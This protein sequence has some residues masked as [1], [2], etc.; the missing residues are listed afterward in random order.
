MKKLFATLALSLFAA[1][2]MAWEMGV[3]GGR[4]FSSPDRNYAGFTLGKSL[5][6][7]SVTAG[8]HR[9]V[10]GDNDQDRFSVTAGYDVAKVGP[11]TITPVVG[12]AYL[13]NQTSANGLALAAGVEASLPIYK[14]VD[15]VVDWTHQVGQSRVNA[16][17]GNRVSAGVRYAF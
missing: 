8:Y 1:S 5:G 9:A 7:V 10:L 14:K 4:D 16:S 11:V 15:L 13:N 12:L 3:T 17:N 6:L 2:T